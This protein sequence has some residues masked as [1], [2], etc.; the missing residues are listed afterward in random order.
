MK[1][2]NKKFKNL[3]EFLIAYKSEASK[4]FNE[5]H[6]KKLEKIANIL[7]KIYKSQKTLYVCGNGGSAS[8]AEHFVCDH[9]KL[10]ATT[11]KFLPKVIS[12]SSNLPL[13]TAIANDTDYSNI[14]SDQLKYNY[15]PGDMIFLIS[16]S[17]NSPNI[18]KALKFA[19]QKKIFSISFT[20]FDGGKAKELSNINIHCKSYNYGIVEMMHHNYMNIIAQYLRQKVLSKSDIKKI[21]F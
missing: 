5:N 6:V 9:Q 12:L 19:K 13:I 1:F 11:K 18:V 16:A 10:L 3:R 4:M 8:I 20:G 7:S 14:F 2:P 17:G 21:Y 15:R